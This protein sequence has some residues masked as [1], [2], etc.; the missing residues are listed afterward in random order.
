M[1]LVLEQEF[2]GC[3]ADD[4]A[5]G[6]EGVHYQFEPKIF[7]NDRTGETVAY[8]ILQID[9]NDSREIEVGISNSVKQPMQL[10]APAVNGP[11]YV[12]SNE[13]E[14][15][16]AQAIKSFTPRASQHQTKLPN[17]SRGTVIPKRVFTLEY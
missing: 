2:I 17:S 5:T 13:S 4:E 8:Q 15:F 11:F 9:E 7:T 14:P 6:E 3:D 12:I 10:L 16:T 1:S